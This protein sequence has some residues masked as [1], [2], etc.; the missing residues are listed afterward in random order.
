MAGVPWQ[1]ASITSA[2][3]PSAASWSRTNSASIP[4]VSSVAIIETDIC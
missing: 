1:P 4:L 2:G 3:A